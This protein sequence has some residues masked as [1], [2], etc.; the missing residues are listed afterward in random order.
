MIQQT[1]AIIRNTFFESVRQPIM[2][3]VLVIATIAI[4][5]A[6]P[7][8]AFTMQNDQRMLID[9]GLASVF[10][11]GAL[12][13]AFV[14]TNVFGR[15]IENRTALTVIS[16]PVSR[17]LFILGKYIGVAIAI[18]L[19]TLYMSFVFLL[20]EQHTVL[21]TVRDPLHV[22]V[23][24]F[25][26]AAGLIGLG[27]GIWCN[28]FYN[29]V[30]SSTVICVTTPLAGVA[31]LLSMMFKPDFTVQPIS[32]GFRGQL[33][34]ALAGIL[35]AILVLSAIAL[36]ASTRLG[37]V[38]T[39]CVTVGVFLAGMLSD[40]FFGRQ[41]MKIEQGWIQRVSAADPAQLQPVLD[42][43][44][45]A[46]VRHWVLQIFTEKADR[47]LTA[48]RCRAMMQVFKE[49]QRLKVP[50][51]SSQQPVDIAMLERQLES[52]A[53]SQHELALTLAVQAAD[54]VQP[55][56]TRAQVAYNVDWPQTVERAKGECETINSKKTLIYPPLLRDLATRDEL[57]ARAANRTA[58]SIV[59][60]FQVLWL[61]DSLTQGHLIPL[62][63]VGV[64][65]LYGGLYIVASL[66]LATLLFQRREI[67]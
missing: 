48:A 6:N 3:V 2:L 40:W 52:E 60:N 65:A 25:G 43:L 51:T 53:L 20:V 14:A 10:V 41:L 9:T 16:K 59:P 34:L 67:G 1:F 12:L 23:L 45:P 61:S 17:P 64:T 19:G 47:E 28:Y 26:F 4:I 57:L 35:I 24:A 11:G 63:Y 42:H 33:W 36:A 66:S 7:L 39:L 13:A 8:S 5:L 21:Q 38:M 15:E 29:T 44:D 46:G 22:P 54:A 56:L 31:Y 27:V 58:Y 62:S 49:R 37:Q 55:P 50:S 18:A 32:Q 30:F